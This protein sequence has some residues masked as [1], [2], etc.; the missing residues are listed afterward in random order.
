MLAVAVVAGNGM[1]RATGRAVGLCMQLPV[2]HRCGCAAVARSSPLP[3]CG[4]P[5]G[6]G[7]T[8]LTAIV[9]AQ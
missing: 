8:G 7:D 4:L 6:G 5:L 3:P 2:G 1:L 9:R